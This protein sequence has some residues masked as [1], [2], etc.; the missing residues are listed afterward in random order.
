MDLNNGG[1]TLLLALFSLNVYSLLLSTT[2]MLEMLVL[3][4]TLCLFYIFEKEIKMDI[5][6]FFIVLFCSALLLYSKQTGYFILGGFGLYLL[7]DKR[8]IREKIKGFFALGGGFILNLPWLIKNQILYGNMLS[9]GTGVAD[10]LSNNQFISLPTNVAYLSFKT[11]EYFYRIPPLEKLNYSGIFLVASRVYYFG[12]LICGAILSFLILEGI[13]KY[14]REYFRWIILI[15]PTLVLSIM[16]TFFIYHHAYCDF[17]R[18]LFSFYF[19]LF[20]FGIRV[21]E[22]TKGVKKNVLCLIVILF[23]L[24]SIVTSVATSYKFKTQD[25][26]L[27]IVGTKIQNLNGT[28]ICN[29]M[30]SASV[31]K[32][33]SG[34]EVDFLKET[35]I[36]D[37]DV[38]CS[39]RIVLETSKYKLSQ[40]KQSPYEICL[41]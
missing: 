41:K 20:S 36:I 12:F 9:V 11:L 23:C 24:L 34:K 29:D 3:F 6:W 32:Y 18:Y 30:F 19:I 14:G 26:E 37:L 15:L 22:K 5:K 39:G 1:R 4:F 35:N 17:G 33:Y 25:D 31:L 16:W 7:F 40:G 27:R 21:I 10:S 8:E 13:L 38:N 2:I 28:F